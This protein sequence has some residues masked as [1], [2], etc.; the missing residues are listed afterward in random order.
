MITSEYQQPRPTVN[1]TTYA[2]LKG[3]PSAAQ[4]Q[5]L[6]ALFNQG[7]MAEAE[8]LAW[9]LTQQYPKHGS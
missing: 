6:M 2:A 1:Q 9:M 7:A 3:A 4:L 5:Q 8:A